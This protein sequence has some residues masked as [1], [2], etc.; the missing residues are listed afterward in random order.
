[1]EPDSGAA[2]VLLG[3]QL[4]LHRRAHPQ[5]LRDRRARHAGGLHADLPRQHAHRR[6]VAVDAPTVESDD[7]LQRQSGRSRRR[8]LAHRRSRP[9]SQ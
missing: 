5:I 7:A 8:R 1:M 9:R 4:Q 2:V 3:H 6:L